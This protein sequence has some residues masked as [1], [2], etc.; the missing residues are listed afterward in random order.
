VKRT[1]QENDCRLIIKLI[2]SDRESYNVTEVTEFT[3]PLH[4]H[5]SSQ[6]HVT[7]S[8]KASGQ[9]LSFGGCLVAD[10]VQNLP[11]KVK[12]CSAPLVKITGLCGQ[13][14]NYIGIKYS[15]KSI[16]ED[17]CQGFQR[18]F[19]CLNDPESKQ[20]FTQ[21]NHSTCVFPVFLGPTD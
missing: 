9:N 11:E 8:A 2:R 18:P 7:F 20:T 3:S 21:T 4:Q 6:S 15:L 10:C 17:T 16:N 12:P 13:L 1:R 14:T 19:T 5:L